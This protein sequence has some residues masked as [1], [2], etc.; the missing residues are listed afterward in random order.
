MKI[1]ASEAVSYL[2]GYLGWCNANRIG[3]S[4]LF[5]VAQGSLGKAH[6]AVS[7]SQAFSWTFLKKSL[8]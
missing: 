6:A 5:R 8:M 3:C 4:V 7:M 2:L 1:A